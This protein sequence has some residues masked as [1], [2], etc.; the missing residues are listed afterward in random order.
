MSEKANKSLTSPE[1]AP[2]FFR[3]LSNQLKLVFRLM[4]DRRV[5]LLLKIL[6]LAAFI[7]L[8]A[9]DFLLGPIDDALVLSLG[10]FTFVELCPDEVVQEHRTALGMGS[11]SSPAPQDGED[12]HG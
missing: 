10:L 6:P 5:N 3:G 2:G 9:P 11:S 12:A 1:P 8:I 4:A 7:Y